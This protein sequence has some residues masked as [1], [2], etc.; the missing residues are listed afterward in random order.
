MSVLMTTCHLSLSASVQI[1]KRMR[2]KEKR[3]RNYH[4]LLAARPEALIKYIEETAGAKDLF[5]EA[6]KSQRHPLWRE[7]WRNKGAGKCHDGST[8]ASI[9]VKRPRG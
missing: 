4:E 5:R 7:F 2:K 3:S 9:R 8:F 1:E 6:M